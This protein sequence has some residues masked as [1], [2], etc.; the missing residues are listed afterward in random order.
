MEVTSTNEKENLELVMNHAI[1]LYSEDK[2]SFE[3]KEDLKS[4]GMSDDLATR[5]AEE[6]QEMYNTLI[7]SKAEK[8]IMYGALWLIGG[9]VVTALSYSSSGGKGYILTYGAI[10][11][12]LVQLVVGIYQ[13]MSVD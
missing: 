10:I 4:K 5:I 6:A 7:K 1:V 8:S 3:V 11:G 12:G 9:I 13:R 2:N